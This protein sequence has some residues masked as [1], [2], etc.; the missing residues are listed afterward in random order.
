MINEL[1]RFLDFLKKFS[2]THKLKVVYF[3]SI[4]Y[5]AVGV[6]H[7][8][9]SDFFLHI[10]PDYLPWH[11]EL[12]YLSGIFE[13]ILGI[14]ILF[15]QTRKL[16][17]WG[18]IALLIAVFPANIYLAQSLQAQ[19]ALEISSEIFKLSTSLKLLTIN[20]KTVIIIINLI[21]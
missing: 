2:L 13:I 6:T 8:T 17:G 7:F 9:N 14:L 4:S 20:G 21:K 15:Q 10:M 12:V 1:N 11:L 16:A 19:Q 3:M 5:V 18:L